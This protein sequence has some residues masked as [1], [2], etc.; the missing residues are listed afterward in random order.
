MQIPWISFPALIAI[1]L[2]FAALLGVVSGAARGSRWQFAT[3]CALAFGGLLF[4]GANLA[5]P[6]PMW[7]NSLL[8]I[9]SA[10]A[11]GLGYQFSEEAKPRAAFGWYYAGAAMLLVLVWGLVQDWRSPTLI[12]GLSA[13]LAA[14]ISL[15]RGLL[16][17]FN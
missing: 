14:G 12:L 7:A 11:F 10:A 3:Y 5:F 4:L 1:H 13:A 17:K 8:W 16:A 2:G 15:R 9:A 6:L